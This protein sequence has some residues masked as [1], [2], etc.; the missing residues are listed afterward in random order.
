M[1]LL[2][3][4]AERQTGA[5]RTLTT[6]APLLRSFLD[7]LGPFAEASRP[8][9]R[10]LGEAAK[11]G[12][13]AVQAARPRLTELGRAAGGLPELGGNLALVLEHLHDRKHAVEKDARSPTGQGFTG[14]EAFLRYIYAQ[15][16]R[17]RP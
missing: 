5:L 15:C 2:G 7:E 12:R 14:F 10:T 13:P 9:V 8:A 6:Q 3:A 16:A 1:P 11:A 17:S 4:A